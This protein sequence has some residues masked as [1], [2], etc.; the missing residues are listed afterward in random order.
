MN[1]WIIVNKQTKTVRKSVGVVWVQ[2]ADLGL[3]QEMMGSNGTVMISLYSNNPACHNHRLK[4]LR[5]SCPQYPRYCLVKNILLWSWLNDLKEEVHDQRECLVQLLFNAFIKSQED[6]VYCPLIE[7]I[8]NAKLEGFAN[9]V[10]KRLKVQND[11]EIWGRWA[12]S[13]RIRFHLDK[14]TVIHLG[15]TN[16]S[17]SAKWKA[18]A[19]T[20]GKD[21]GSDKWIANWN[22]AHY[23]AAV[24][25]KLV[26]NV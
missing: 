14:C 11:P 23:T 9:A 13:N 3:A 8:D 10:A 19:Q 7:S 2:R 18:F 16:H 24:K 20:T 1:E 4:C 22:E 26:C 15:K 21:L 25:Q 17:T 5:N 12:N 6:K